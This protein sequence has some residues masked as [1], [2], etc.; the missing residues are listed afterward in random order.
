MHQRVCDIC[1]KTGSVYTRCQVYH[2][3]GIDW[4]ERCFGIKADICNNCMFVIS[5]FIAKKI[6]ITDAELYL[7]N[8][9]VNQKTM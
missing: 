4:L 5:N 7:R 9:T 6:L 1:G 3:G 2:H 8:G